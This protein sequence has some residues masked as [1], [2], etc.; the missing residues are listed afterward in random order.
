MTTSDFTRDRISPKTNWK[1]MFDILEGQVNSLLIENERLRDALTVLSKENGTFC[2]DCPDIREF[3][4]AAL[5]G[6]E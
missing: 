2:C 3:A 6:K 4:R 1:A 5:E